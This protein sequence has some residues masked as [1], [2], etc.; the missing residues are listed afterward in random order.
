MKIDGQMKSLAADING[1]WAVDLQGNLQLRTGINSTHP[2]G[3]SWTAVNMISFGKTASFY[4]FLS[5]VFG[6]RNL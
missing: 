5:F 1:V 3:S 4:F 2:A 6:A